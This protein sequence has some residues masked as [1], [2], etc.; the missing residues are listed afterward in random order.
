MTFLSKSTATMLFSV[1]T[2]VCC[3]SANAAYR[4]GSV[5]ANSSRYYTYTASPGETFVVRISGDGDTDVDLYVRDAAGRTVCSGTRAIDE[6]RCSV[7]SPYG[8]VYRIQ[9][10]NLGDVFNEVP[11]WLA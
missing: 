7:H 4:E 10:K 3:V 6:E 1:L 8:G 9:L 2:A 5:Q 11:L